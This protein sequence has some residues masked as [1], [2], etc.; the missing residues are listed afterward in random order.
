MANAMMQDGML[1]IVMS[2]DEVLAA[3]RSAQA[4]QNPAS[5][6]PARPQPAPVAPAA[7]GGDG[8]TGTAG[9]W[10]AG[11]GPAPGT[12]T[13]GDQVFLDDILKG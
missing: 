7:T 9:N 6:Q 11:A 12:R 2:R 4:N 1:V 5:P 3:I 8:A 13:E 10:T